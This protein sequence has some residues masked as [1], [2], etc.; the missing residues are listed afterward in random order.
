MVLISPVI[1][2]DELLK[3]NRGGGKMD[4][5]VTILGILH[6]AWAAIEILGAMIVFMVIAGGGILSGDVDI[7]TITVTIGTLISFFLVVTALPSLVGGIAILKKREWG[8]IL[9]LV[10]GF[11]HMLNI[12]FGTVLG[13]YTIWVL[14][15]NETRRLFVEK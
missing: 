11:F 12:P 7:M 10:M 3:R 9:T 13:I 4:Q 8:R 6:I 14:L 5:H 1:P 15:N 2:F